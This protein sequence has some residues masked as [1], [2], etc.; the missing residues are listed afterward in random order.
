VAGKV[1]WKGRKKIYGKNRPHH[2]NQRC[3]GVSPEIERLKVLEWTRDA[4][5]GGQSARNRP[6]KDVGGGGLEGSSIVLNTGGVR[7]G[8]DLLIKASR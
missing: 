6:Q 7:G 5:L 3:K 1:W 8:G 2:P 4:G